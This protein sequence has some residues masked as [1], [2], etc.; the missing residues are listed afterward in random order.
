MALDAKRQRANRVDFF[1]WCVQLPKSILPRGKERMGL[2]YLIMKKF[3]SVLVLN[4]FARPLWVS[5]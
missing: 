5:K 4:R 2:L 1:L 3:V